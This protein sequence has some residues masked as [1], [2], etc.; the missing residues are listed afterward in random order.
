MAKKRAKRAKKTTKRKATKRPAKKKKV[1][2]KRAPVRKRV[3]PRKKVTY[4][5]DL[6]NRVTL[7]AYIL[8]ILSVL[9]GYYTQ[10]YLMYLAVAVVLVVFGHTYART[11]RK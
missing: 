6:Q 1:T 5:S 10:N 9:Y 2:K 11:R 7:G 3:A 4:K 8:A